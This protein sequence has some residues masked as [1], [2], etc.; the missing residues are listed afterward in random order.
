MQHIFLWLLK[1]KKWTVRIAVIWTVLILIACLLPGNEVPDVKIPMIDKW[2]H[3]II[4]GGFTFLWLCV[5]RYRNLRFGIIMLL[6]AVAFGY[7]VELLQGSGITPGRSYD[8]MDVVADGIG[9]AIGVLIFFI[10]RT[11][12]LRK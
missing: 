2:V 4:F 5:K 11:I 3:F 6:L 9:G 10:L 12:S 8:L 1:N 7:A